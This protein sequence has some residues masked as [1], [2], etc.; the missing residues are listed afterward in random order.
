MNS[1]FGSAIGALLHAVSDRAHIAL[2]GELSKRCRPELCNRGS[3]RAI[4]LCNAASIRGQ[5]F[6]PPHA[7]HRAS[8]CVPARSFTTFPVLSGLTGV[9][10]G[11]RSE[12]RR[13]MADHPQPSRKCAAIG[14]ASPA[15]QRAQ[16]PPERCLACRSASA[17]AHAASRPF[18]YAAEDPRKWQN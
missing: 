6:M 7:R 11:G 1:F 12:P 15:L 4:L 3:F 13:R 18:A 16:S 8:I 14:A 9:R 5:T 10:T 2:Q 17:M